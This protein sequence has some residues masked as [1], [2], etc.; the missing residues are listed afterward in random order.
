[1]EIK[2]SYEENYLINYDQNILLEPLQ[3]AKECNLTLY[4]TNQ[5]IYVTIKKPVNY[6]MT[7]TTLNEDL[8]KSLLMSNIDLNQKEDLKWIKFLNY[9]TCINFVYI[10]KIFSNINREYFRLID[11]MGKVTVV[12]VENGLIYVPECAIVQNIRINRAKSDKC[13]KELPVIFSVKDEEHYGFLHKDGIVSM[14][15]NE[16]YCLADSDSIIFFENNRFNVV[17][18]IGND[19][20]TIDFKEY[21]WIKYNGYNKQIKSLNTHHPDFLMTSVDEIRILKDIIEHNIDNKPYFIKPLEDKL[22]RGTANKFYEYVKNS[23]YDYSMKFWRIVY[24]TFFVLLAIGGMFIIGKV[25]LK[26]RKN[27]LCKRRKPL[28]LQMSPVSETEPI[29]A[30]VTETIHVE[31]T[32]SIDL[33]LKSIVQRDVDKP[34]KGGVSI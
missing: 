31:E 18:R 17:K 16:E 2:L 22:A 20:I 5:G 27:H 23:V 10:L 6:T 11:E 3:K 1:M 24:I 9:Q 21:N 8:I 34:S 30:D 14:I 4:S 33:R 15:G 32:D 19:I 26:L 7:N 29:N 25:I 28:E 13:F 12:Y